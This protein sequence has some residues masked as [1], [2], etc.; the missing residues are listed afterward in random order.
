MNNC[1]SKDTIFPSL[2]Q[3]ICV[4]LNMKITVFLNAMSCRGTELLSFQK[5]L[6]S[7]FSL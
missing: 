6:L 5:N 2:E 3:K 4:T 1:V 7:L